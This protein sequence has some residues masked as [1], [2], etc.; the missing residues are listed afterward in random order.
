MPVRCVHLVQA[1][2]SNSACR[3][4]GKVVANTVCAACAD[5]EGPDRGLG[6]VVHRVAQATGLTK[7]VKTVFKSDCGC[8]KRRATLN[9][10]VSFKN[11]ETDSSDLTPPAD[12]GTV[13]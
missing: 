9:T 5:Y 4:N 1:R 11:P 8:E 12:E 13:S 3:F 10:M 7:V 2:C 6:D